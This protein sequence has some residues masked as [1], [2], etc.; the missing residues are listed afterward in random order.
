[1]ILRTLALC[2]CV[3]A[4]LLAA[5][6]EPAITIRAGKSDSLNHALAVQF[7]EA[8]AIAVNGAY[9]LDVQE[10]QGSVANV[11]DAA[12]APANYLFTAGSTVIAAAQHGQK[13][14]APNPRYRDIRALV[15]IPPQTVHWVVRQDSNITSLYG[16]AG[17]IFISGA[18]GSVSE[19]VTGEVFE[20]IGI[21]HD[22]QIM[23]I[24]AAAAPAA[25]KAKQVSGFAI[26]GPYP[27]PALVAL[28][29]TTPI[30]LLSLPELQLR[31]VAAGDDSIAAEQVPKRAYPGLESDV[32]V[33]A[34]PA[35]IYTT[36]RMSDATAYAITKAFW[37]Q[38]PAL[39]QKNPPWQAVSLAML[40]TLGVRLH[41]G[42]L[43]YYRETH[44]P[45][46]KALR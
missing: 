20:E 2:L 36:T 18:K 12:K 41:P 37:S 42:A 9:T 45:V 15:P 16:L 30:R 29:S 46:P 31:K 4:P 10:S 23:D 35:G 44:V 38:R 27:L 13:P 7:A 24:D 32:T 28:A 3:V 21:E 40:A 43:R 19:R 14:F 11:M 26:A 6:K 8:V 34:L 5:A 17:Q 22:V 1:V 33:L 25:L 39:E